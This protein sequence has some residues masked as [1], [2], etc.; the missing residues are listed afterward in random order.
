MKV[1]FATLYLPLYFITAWVMSNRNLSDKLRY[2]LPLS[3]QWQCPS[4]RRF[5]VYDLLF[6]TLALPAVIVATNIAVKKIM[7]GVLIGQ[8]QLS[9][10]FYALFYVLMGFAWRR[11]ASISIGFGE[12]SK[13]FFNIGRLRDFFLRGPALASVNNN[14]Q[15]EIESFVDRVVE[16]ITASPAVFTPLFRQNGN[17]L[18]RVGTRVSRREADEIR[19]SLLKRAESDF[20]LLYGQICNVEMIPLIDRDKP[21]MR[22]PQITF[23]E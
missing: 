8:P 7:Q 9:G 18:S 1:G 21:L 20:Q 17:G 12:T 11:A 5:W 14:L 19:A 23:R 15:R 13:A 16:A 2:N 4:I 6:S 10:L 22:V 3:L